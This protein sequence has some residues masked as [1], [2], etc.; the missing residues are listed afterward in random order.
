MPGVPILWTSNRKLILASRSEARRDLLASTGIPFETATAE[1]DERTT[2]VAFLSEGGEAQK[3]AGFL[4]RAK[5]LDVSRRRPGA[6]CL[7][8]DQV[9]N[10]GGRIFHRAR[11]IQDAATQL[12]RLSGRTHRLTSAFAI[13]QDGRVAY[14][15]EDHAD[16]TMRSLS[17][18]QIDLYLRLVGEA[19]LTSVGG[20][21]LEK[22]GV[23]L[24]E[25]IR[26]DYATILGLP[27]LKLLS[28]LR[29]EGALAL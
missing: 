2:E 26:G 5:A 18:A 9:L 23:H 19:A 8:A 15:A 11:T 27:I 3:L 6:L 13:V 21:Q 14:E 25:E 20:Y 24:M 16:M 4:A 17:A 12:A 1:I 7:G 29:L 10:L 28:C 22:F